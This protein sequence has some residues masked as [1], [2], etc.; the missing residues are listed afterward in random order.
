MHVD[1]RRKVLEPGDTLWVPRG[2]LHGFGSRD[3]AIFE[4]ISTTNF[5]DDSFYADKNI[6]NLSREDRKTRLLNW[7]RHQ[8]ER[9][10]G[11]ELAGAA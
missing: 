3:G 8:L 7:G 4:E 2:V 6:A 11:D 5:G 10:E 1:G 9:I